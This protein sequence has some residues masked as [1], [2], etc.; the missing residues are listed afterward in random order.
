MIVLVIPVWV[1]TV[2]KRGGKREKREVVRR[3]EGGGVWTR[4]DMTFF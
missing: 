4:L 2:Q 3:R 1:E